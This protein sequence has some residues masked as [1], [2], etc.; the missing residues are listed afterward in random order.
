MFADRNIFENEN[1]ILSESQNESVFYLTAEDFRPLPQVIIFYLIL[2]NVFTVIFFPSFQ[3][4][5]H[6]GYNLITYLLMR[7]KLILITVLII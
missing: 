4:H 6:F 3:F 2:N 7:I 1:C 5:T